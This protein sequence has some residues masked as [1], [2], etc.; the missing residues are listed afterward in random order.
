MLNSKRLPVKSHI[1]LYSIHSHSRCNS[2][3]P[4]QI[5]D[6]L[7]KQNQLNPIFSYLTDSEQISSKWLQSATCY[8]CHRLPQFSQKATQDIVVLKS[9]F[10]VKRTFIISEHFLIST[11]YQLFY[12]LFLSCNIINY[13]LSVLILL[14]LILFIYIAFFTDLFILQLHLYFILR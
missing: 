9:V 1:F 3:R 5:P 2:Y 10:T 7:G 8:V 13:Y 12:Y 4:S 11:I 14:R 6:G